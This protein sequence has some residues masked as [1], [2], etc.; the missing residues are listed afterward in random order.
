MKS[1]RFFILLIGL[2]FVPAE[3]YLK[4]ISVSVKKPSQNETI[5]LVEKITNLKMS[6]G[7]AFDVD[8]LRGTQ[9]KIEALRP[10]GRAH[11][12]LYC[13][14]CHQEFKPAFENERGFE[15]FV[16]SMANISLHMMT[17]SDPRQRMPK[18]NAYFRVSER[19]RLDMIR[20]LQSK[21][22]INSH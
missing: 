5:A 3:G 18:A 21:S 13:Y 17:L 4:A 6:R 2:V 12:A 22:S 1:V 9:E 16:E 7:L 19:T 14:Q 8:D 11:F 20:F 10:I 15:I